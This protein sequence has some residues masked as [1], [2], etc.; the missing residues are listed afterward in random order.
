MGMSPLDPRI[1]EHLLQKVIQRE[2][3]VG[4]YLLV[5]PE[6]DTFSLRVCT[7][8]DR[9]IFRIVKAC[10]HKDREI[11]LEGIT[12]TSLKF[13]EH[14]WCPVSL[15]D[16][17]TIVEERMRIGHT[18]GRKSLVETLEVVLHRLRIE[19]IHHVTFTAG[20]CTLHLLAS[21]CNVTGYEKGVITVAGK[22]F[23]ALL[24]ILNVFGLC[25]DLKNLVQVEI[26]IDLMQLWEVLLFLVG[27]LRNDVA[28]MPRGE[29]DT[30]SGLIDTHLG[31]TERPT[32]AR[33]HIDFDA[34][35]LAFGLNMAQHTHPARR[36]EVNVVLLVALNAIDG[37][38]LDGADTSLGVGLKVICQVGTIDSTAQPPPT[39]AR[40]GLLLYDRPFLSINNLR[41]C[42][43]QEAKAQHRKG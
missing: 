22:I 24:F 43:G 23:L 40:L 2:T 38:N 31:A 33:V 10:I 6:S 32:S 41:R 26:G 20:C 13:V 34:Q 12:A 9:E 1:G 4:D 28:S 42:H 21:L 15:I 14:G 11:F 30:S 19:V 8:V 29:I 39:G 17:I 25:L 35:T 27:Q 16:L 5:C 37:G 7:M 36:Q 3:I 18:T